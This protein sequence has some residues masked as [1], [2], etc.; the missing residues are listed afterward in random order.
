MN[1]LLIGLS[2]LFDLGRYLNIGAAMNLTLYLDRIKPET[3]I[4]KLVYIA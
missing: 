1:C 3:S 2:I 4:D